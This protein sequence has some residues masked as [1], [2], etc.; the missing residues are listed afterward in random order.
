VW[1]PEK[2]NLGFIGVPLSAAVS[3]N[4]LALLT[5]SYILSHISY[6]ALRENATD[7]FNDFGILVITG[8]NGVVLKV[9]HFWSTE[10]L[11]GMCQVQF[12]SLYLFRRYQSRR[13]CKE[14]FRL[15]NHKAHTIQIGFYHVSGTVL[16]A[17][18]LLDHQ[19]RPSFARPGR[20]GSVS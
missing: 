18:F 19:S 15:A 3:H 10:L 12:D 9:S 17:R 14:H 13:A 1:G 6:A 4:M 11:G 5:A 2:Y 7:L 20:E 16:G 8:W